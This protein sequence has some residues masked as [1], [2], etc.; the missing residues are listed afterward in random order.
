MKKT[1]LYLQKKYEILF[2]L[3]EWEHKAHFPSYQV[4]VPSYYQSTTQKRLNLMVEDK[5][6]S[7]FASMLQLSQAGLASAFPQFKKGKNWVLHKSKT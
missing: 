1:V 5:H 2:F 7:M 4:E 6:C 3:L